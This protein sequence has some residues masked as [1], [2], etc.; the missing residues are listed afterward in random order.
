MENFLDIRVFVVIGFQ[1]TNVKVFILD[2]Q[3][4]IGLKYDN[5]GAFC[6]NSVIRYIHMMF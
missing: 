1:Q 5:Y 6:C 2:I 3:I 4:V